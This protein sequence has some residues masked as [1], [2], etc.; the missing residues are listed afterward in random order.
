MES[1]A[2]F[3]GYL[4][5]LCFM[6]AAGILVGLYKAY[7][8]NKGLQWFLPQYSQIFTVVQLWVIFCIYGIV[9]TKLP[10]EDDKK[11]DTITIM[12]KSTKNYL[13][14]VVALSIAL[15]GFYIVKSWS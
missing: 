2:K 8:V 14:K 5:I 12:A 3:I 6:Y 11:E 10:E 4:T 15:L 9:T 1:I 13:V 7:V